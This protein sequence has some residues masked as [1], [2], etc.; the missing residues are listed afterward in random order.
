LVEFV[1]RTGIIGAECRVEPLNRDG[2]PSSSRI[3]G[4]DIATTILQASERFGASLIVMGTRGRTA[5]AALLLGS[6]TEQVM[7][8]AR[9]PVLAFKEPGS[10]MGFAA[11]LLTRLREPAPV[12]AAS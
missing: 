1:A 9:L 8:R 12:L 7:V 2:V 6:V 4:A 10:P 3:E 5:S 11:A